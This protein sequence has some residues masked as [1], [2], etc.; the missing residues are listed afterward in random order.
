MQS[1]HRGSDLIGCRRIINGFMLVLNNWEVADR[2]REAG[3]KGSL[4]LCPPCSLWMHPSIL[5]LLPTLPPPCC[6]TQGHGAKCHGLNSLN[7]RA[8]RNS[9][10]LVFHFSNKGSTSHSSGWGPQPS[11]AHASCIQSQ[12]R[13]DTTNTDSSLTS[14]AFSG[15]LFLLQSPTQDSERF[16]LLRLFW[17]EFLV[18]KA[19]RR[20]LP[21][22]VVEYF[23]VCAFCIFFS[24]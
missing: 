19:L 11:A 10:S 7:L 6:P 16:C 18:S 24:P 12:C 22:H 8:T 2:A 17:T 20:A 14:F 5:S 13:C 4:G 23:L 1:C 21:S 15:V 3:G 9:S